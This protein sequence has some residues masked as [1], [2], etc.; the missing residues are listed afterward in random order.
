MPNNRSLP[1]LQS[2]AGFGLLGSLVMLAVLSTLTVLT[3]DSMDQLGREKNGERFRNGADRLAQQVRDQLLNQGACTNTLAGLTLDGT[4]DTPV[5][6]IRDSINGVTQAIGGEYDDRSVRLVGVQAGPYVDLVA[7]NGR[8]TVT[9]RI[10]SISEVSGLG[11]V[12]R[13]I[14]VRTTKAGTTL[15][16]CSAEAAAANADAWT[17]AANG[18]DIYLMNQVGIG[19]D[20][21][22]VRLD[23]KGGLING[24]FNCRKVI[25]AHSNVTSLAQCAIDEYVVSGGGR[26]TVSP[27]VDPLNGGFIHQNMP[28]TDLSGWQLDC[29]KA[30]PKD[31]MAG[32][33]ISEAWA[34]CCKK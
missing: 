14:S 17:K 1:L 18:T 30:E 6:N 16:T 12:V 21:P 20:T 31:P 11:E 4:T 25:G 15:S 5:P 27:D 29:H 22:Q 2:E 9:L 26:C 23:V 24:Q 32:V 33:P 8:L 19:T 28:T 7:P 34:I 13:T 3:L 10:Q